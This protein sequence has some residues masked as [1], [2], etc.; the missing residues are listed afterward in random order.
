[1]A[2]VLSFSFLRAE[3]NLRRSAS[4]SGEFERVR[5]VREGRCDR[6]KRKCSQS[7]G[8]RRSLV[9]GAKEMSRE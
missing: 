3:G 2:L 9:R 8:R 5:W 7:L 4:E 1:M 6:D